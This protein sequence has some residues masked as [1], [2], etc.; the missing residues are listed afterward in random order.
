M[1]K[2]RLDKYLADAGAGTRSEVKNY[3]RKGRVTVEGA[4]CKDASCKIDPQEQSV[5]LDQKI[6]RYTRFEYYMMN[7]AAGYVSASRDNR[8][9]TV[10][11]EI[12]SPRKAELFPVGRLDVDTEGLLLITNDGGLAHRL[13]APGRHVDKVYRAVVEGQVTQEDIA[14]FAAGLDIGEKRQTLPAVLLISGFDGRRSEVR[15]TVREGKFHQIRRMFHAVG[16]E[17]LYL[18]RIQ[19]GSLRLD[20]ALARGQY[21]PLTPEEIAQLREE[22]G[23]GE[24]I[25]ADLKG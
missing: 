21:R 18:E 11:D 2:I 14:R 9:P 8:Y 10:M 12:Q 25:F 15:V 23:Y 13:L 22:A 16:K 6:V 4:V 24:R 7:K 3:I 20:E 5:F 1:E 17:V 19:M